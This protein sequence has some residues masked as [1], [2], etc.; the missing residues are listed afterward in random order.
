M[1]LMSFARSSWGISRVIFILVLQPLVNFVMMLA[2]ASRNSC[3]QFH[4][5]DQATALHKSLPN[6]LSAFASPTRYAASKYAHTEST[7]PAARVQKSA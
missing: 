7:S 6:M 1:G 3:G 2:A 5:Q 4:Q